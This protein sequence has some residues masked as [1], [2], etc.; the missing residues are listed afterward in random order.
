MGPH[1]EEAGLNFRLELSDQVQEKV[2]GDPTRL[3]QILLI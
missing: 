3:R 2:S 1:A